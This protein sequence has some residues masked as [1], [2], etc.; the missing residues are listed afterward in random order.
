MKIGFYGDSFCCEISNPHSIVKRYDT[1][2]KK[3]QRN[4]DADIVH[5][6]VG[7]SSVWDVILKQF[8]KN[9]VPDVCIFCWTDDNRLYNR[10]VRNITYSS[11]RNKK[12]KDFKLN[13]LFYYNTISAAK[14]YF[15]Y[16]HDSEKSQIEYLAALQYFD[17]NILNHIKN[18]VIHLWS[19]EQKYVWKNGIDS[20]ISLNSLVT[21]STFAA[22]HLDGNEANDKVYKIIKNIIDVHHR[23]V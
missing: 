12:I 4:Y 2:I 19:F 22:N 18:Q 17:N 16:L 10:H 1:F 8:D 9:T 13:D 11:I 5:L 20:G 7:G 23:P 6:G 21:G 14:K 3:L 15:E